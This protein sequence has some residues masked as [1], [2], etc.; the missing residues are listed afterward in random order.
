MDNG[1]VIAFIAILLIVLY[2]F[3]INIFIKIKN[4]GETINK[5]YFNIS[6][7]NSVVNNINE[8]TANNYKLIK[9]NADNSR[10]LRD[11]LQ[12]YIN[13][14][15]ISNIDNIINILN[16]INKNIN[17]VLLGNND[18]VKLISNNINNIDNIRNKLN[19]IKTNTD[20]ILL[21]IDNNANILKKIISKL[22]TDKPN[23]KDIVHVP[24]KV[25]AKNSL[26][27]SKNEQTIN[28]NNKK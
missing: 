6:K 2:L 19:I 8:E 3:V 18:I 28:D 4:A 25:K 17:F 24:K 23:C 16:T 1:F 27:N 26:L 15:N 13:N 22:N 7:I 10:K 11:S 9:I 20:I 5:L 21:N 12:Y 14:N